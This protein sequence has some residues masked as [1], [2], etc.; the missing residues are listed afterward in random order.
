MDPRTDRA[1]TEEPSVTTTKPT[2]A[3]AIDPKKA[4]K[5]NVY[6]IHVTP[7]LRARVERYRE[8]MGMSSTAEAMR[9]LVIR[10]LETIEEKEPGK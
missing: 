1:R 6:S 10:G 5:K 2:E 9:S 7:Q 3:E 8:A 4:W